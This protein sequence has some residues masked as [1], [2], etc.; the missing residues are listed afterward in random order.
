[1]HAVT[2]L[3]A[4]NGCFVVAG[5]GVLRLLGRRVGPGALAL[6]FLVGVA[7]LLVVTS[8]L[9]TFG[10]VAGIP[11]FVVLALL[12]GAVDLLVVRRRRVDSAGLAPPRRPRLA[13]SIR[14]LLVPLV[15]GSA[16]AVYGGALLRRAAVKPLSEWDA[17]AM[18]TMKAKA[19]ITYGNLGTADHIGAHVDYPILVPMLQALFFRFLG[20]LNTQLVHL[21]YAFIVLAFVVAVWHCVGPMI[22]AAAGGAWAIY[23][24][25]LPGFQANVPDALGDVPVAVFASLAA[26]SLACWLREGE[27]PA[28]LPLFVIFGSAALWSKNEG[29]SAVVMIALVGTAVSARRPFRRYLFPPLLAS[30]AVY[31]SFLPWIWWKRDQGIE[32]D[33]NLVSIFHPVAL[34]HDHARAVQAFN[35]LWGQLSAQGVWLDLPYLVLTLGLVALARRRGGRLAAFALLVPAGLLGTYVLVYAVATDPLGLGWL[36]ATSST[37]VVTTVGLIG[38]ALLPLQLSSLLDAAGSHNTGPAP[39]LDAGSGGV[40]G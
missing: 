36:L 22:G 16:V 7:V 38:V 32:G 10:Y 9:A 6:A 8:S 13:F 26:F 25:L 19:L 30:A 27:E 15:F 4:Y 5:H 33:R 29:L 12:P 18:W 11:A 24:L 34:F 20:E 2:G 40:T 39:S 28:W 1:M 3:V 37:R 14:S 23:A 31:A 21:E 35:D 17:W